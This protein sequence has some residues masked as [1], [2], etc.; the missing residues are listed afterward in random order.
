[1]QLLGYHIIPENISQ[2]RIHCKHDLIDLLL[3][4]ESCSRFQI[5]T[6]PPTKLLIYDNC[7]N[8]ITT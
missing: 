3:S 4:Y 2:W 5:S 8:R 7:T 6:K 1:M